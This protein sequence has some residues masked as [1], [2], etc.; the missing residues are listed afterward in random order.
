M[1][2]TLKDVSKMSQREKLEYMAFALELQIREYRKHFEKMSLDV[3]PKH[4]V[5]VKYHIGEIYHHSTHL[6]ACSQV[7]LND[8][9]KVQLKFIKEK[10]K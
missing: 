5:K 8:V 10:T 9:K 2:K 1:A 6:L 7:L 4:C 3:H